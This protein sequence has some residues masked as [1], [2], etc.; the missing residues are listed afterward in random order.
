LRSGLARA[1]TPTTAADST[2]KRNGG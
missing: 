2:P 1:P